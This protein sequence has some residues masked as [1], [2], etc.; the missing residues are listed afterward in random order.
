MRKVQ[1]RDSY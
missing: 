1:W